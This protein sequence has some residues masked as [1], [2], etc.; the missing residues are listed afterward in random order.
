MLTPAALSS[1]DMFVTTNN[2]YKPYSGDMDFDTQTSLA[3]RTA[4][5]V[6]ISIWYH[7]DVIELIKNYNSD[8][9]FDRLWTETKHKVIE[10]IQSLPL[11]THAKE[12]IL[13]FCLFVGQQI[14][15]WMHIF[16]FLTISSKTMAQIIFFKPRGKIDYLETAKRVILHEEN[17]LNKFRLACLCCL[18]DDIFELWP[19]V[20]CF[21]DDKIDTDLFE[22][23][24]WISY[25]KQ[26]TENLMNEVEYIGNRDV[27]Q[28]AFFMSVANNNTISAKFFLNKMKNEERPIVLD[29]TL[30]N[31]LETPNPFNYETIPFF[32]RYLSSEKLENL[33]RDYPE[34]VLLQFLKFPYLNHFLETANKTWDNL[35]NEGFYCITEEMAYYMSIYFGNHAYENIFQEFW[36]NG[37]DRC[38][39][40]V[41]NK[42]IEGSYLIRLGMFKHTSCVIKAIFQSSTTHQKR[43]MVFSYNGMMFF[44]ALVKRDRLG[45]VAMSIYELF[46]TEERVAC[47]N[48]LI[49]LF[50]NVFRESRSHPTFK[51]E[52]LER[53]IDVLETV[54][55]LLIKGI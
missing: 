6:A 31:I 47:I 14:R 50:E 48:E 21:F 36:N 35:S 27:L 19:K 42:C 17:D 46:T 41:I 33:L 45:C 29:K 13:D 5:T 9:N 49:I 23:K 37:P 7:E 40:Y 43:K 44:D 39:N 22:V 12:I 8:K 34:V 11:T 10:N 26:D 38:Q 25:L 1:R 54:K 51:S 20:K 55:M 24:F 30:R 16:H 3:D 15:Y 52:N 18:E 32:M 53:V 4:T 28:F 2:T